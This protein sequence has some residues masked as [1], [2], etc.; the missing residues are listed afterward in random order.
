MEHVRDKPPIL[1]TSSDFSSMY[2]ISDDFPLRLSETDLKF[3]SD[4]L[5]SSSNALLDFRSLTPEP[6]RNLLKG[7][8][9]YLCYFYYC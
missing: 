8:L 9:D 5:S 1:L 2:P 3:S 4:I 7:Y 6:L